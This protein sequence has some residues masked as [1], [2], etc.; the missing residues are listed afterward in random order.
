M[1]EATE[2]TN[3]VD[4]SVTIF[5]EDAQAEAQTPTSEGTTD[6]TQQTETP[7]ESIADQKEGSNVAEGDKKEGE[8]EKTEEPKEGDKKPDDKDSKEIKL[9]LSKDSSLTAEELQAVS[10]FAKEKG[11]SQEDAQKLLDMREESVKRFREEQLA[12]VEDRKAKWLN[13]LK[14]DKELGGENFATSVSES[15]RVVKQFF[16]E[17]FIRDLETSGLGNYPEFVRGFARIGKLLADDKY[18][19]GGVR[20]GGEK[21]LESYFYG[22]QKGE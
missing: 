15:H 22:D 4:P 13:D 14:A 10:E 19:K 21:T 7:D 5:P 9:E 18:V 3:T 2:T 17:E 16:S 6:Q 11:L 12:L 20:A 1:A 8:G